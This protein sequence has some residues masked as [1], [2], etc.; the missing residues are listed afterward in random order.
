VQNLRS[1]GAGRMGEQQA[2]AGG[3]IMTYQ[4]DFEKYNIVHCGVSGGKDSQ[5]AATWLVKDS[6]VSAD[7]IRLSF[8]DTGNEHEWTYEHVKYIEREL[9]TPIEWIKGELNFYELA[10]KK[11]GFPSA[12]KRF[13]TEHLKM[14]V[15]QG[16]VLQWM[17]DG[18]NVLLITGVRGSESTDRAKLQEFDFDTFFACDILRPIFRWSYAEVINYLTEKGQ[19]INPLYSMGATRVGCFPCVMSRKHEIRMIADN[20]PERIDMIREAEKTTGNGSASFFQMNTVPKK[21]RRHKF[22]GKDGKEW[23]VC[24]IDDVVD[25]SHTARGGKEYDSGPQGRLFGEEAPTCIN[26]S[27][28]CE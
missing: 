2:A 6:G 13:C 16:H 3:E 28:M 5:A 1:G 4:P 15:S 26:N 22:L 27:G 8:C 9:Q 12:K 11:H 20:F 17:R 18:K 21:Y 14:R 24:N 7:K 25:W 23:D 19:H 10:Q